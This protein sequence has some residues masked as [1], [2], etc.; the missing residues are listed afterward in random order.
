MR[1]V[2]LGRDNTNVDKWGYDVLLFRWVALAAFSVSAG[3]VFGASAAV[4]TGQWLVGFFAGGFLGLF[5]CPV[6][7]LLL[8][9]RSLAL[10]L[11]AVLVPTWVVSML[12]TTIGDPLLSIVLTGGAY[13]VLCIGARLT[14]PRVWVRYHPVN[15]QDCGYR[16]AGLPTHTCPECGGEAPEWQQR[17]LGAWPE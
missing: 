5:S 8:A 9:T 16:L 12:S 2:G 10:A 3:A 1:S 14:L 13:V 17:R 4:G 15:C 11:P 6:V 7:I